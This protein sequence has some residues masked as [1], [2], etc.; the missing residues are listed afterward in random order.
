MPSWI[1]AVIVGV[2]SGLLG[3][4]IRIAHERGT[5]LRSR[6]LTA[7]DDFILA[8]NDADAALGNALQPLIDYL[9]GFAPDHE[10]EKPEALARYDA[11]REAAQKVLNLLP[12][13]RLLFGVDSKATR[14]A[15]AAAHGL[16][17]A[18]SNL[19]TMRASTKEGEELAAE[20][21][22][23]ADGFNAARLA[24]FNDANDFIRM[25]RPAISGRI[26]PRR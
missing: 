6:M 25:A 9:Q 21:E 12:R 15:D 20:L 26:T 5:E 14:Y 2:G 4:L 13:L 8:L 19:S 11:S 24:M 7:A 17:T 18:Y 22:L 3:T 1:V 10:E 16:E 23:A